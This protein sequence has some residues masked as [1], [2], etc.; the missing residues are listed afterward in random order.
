M[1]TQILLTDEL[2][3]VCSEAM[4]HPSEWGVEEALGLT[5]IA[6]TVPSFVVTS[7]SDYDGEY[8]LVE[9]Y[10]P[11]VQ[12]IGEIG[13]NPITGTMHIRWGGNVS[14]DYH[15]ELAALLAA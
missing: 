8:V 7:V 14:V 4:A 2:R 6:D 5:K 15:H 10:W 11:N 1:S 9:G 13:G 12:V 3:A